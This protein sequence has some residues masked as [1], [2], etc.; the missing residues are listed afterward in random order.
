[1]G[2]R[3]AGGGPLYLLHCVPGLEP[4]VAEELEAD[5]EDAQIVRTFERF[6]ERTSLLLV[7]TAA[8]PAELLELRTVE[9]AF[10][11]ACEAGEISPAWAGLR[12]VAAAV[13]GDRR[14][15]PALNAV[16]A[17]RPA[18]GRPTYRVVARMSGTHAYRRVDLQR[19]V[20]RA[21]AERL[22]GWR[23]VED[24]AQV[25]LW[26]QLV[27]ETFL[28]GAR[29]SDA[30]M[31]HRTYLE[32]SLRAAL[33][34]TIA[35]AM[36]LLT[37]PQPDDVFLDPMCGSGTLLIERALAG[38]YA[39]LIGGDLDPEAIAATR[40]NVGPRYKPIEITQWDARRLPLDG[41]SVSAIACNL[42]FGKQIGSEASNRALYPA[43]LTEWTRVLRDGGRMVLLTSDR[44]ALQNALRRARTLTMRRSLTV[45]VR[46]VRA[47]LVVLHHRK[48]GTP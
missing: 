44:A 3:R 15:D 6:D 13:A 21:L 33:K 29:L 26:V 41:G 12:A 43:L 18:R 46:G 10:V 5:L 35:A 14:L 38:R 24:D 31:R 22:R 9:D 2:R 1:M 37:D 39:Q 42:P 27:G 19:A 28:L 7:R 4:V 23:E 34:P 36:V 11:L 8:S 30:T 25:E 47:A 32:A 16:Q 20:E 48:D 40:E 17:V 45:S